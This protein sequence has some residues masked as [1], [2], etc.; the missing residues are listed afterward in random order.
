MEKEHLL[1][2]RNKPNKSNEAKVKQKIVVGLYIGKTN[3]SNELIDCLREL[4]NNHSEKLIILFGQN[5][6]TLERLRSLLEGKNLI[7]SVSK[8]ERKFALKRFLEYAKKLNADVQF[9]DLEINPDYRNVSSWIKSF[10]KVMSEDYHFAIGFFNYNPLLK[11]LDHFLLSPIIFSFYGLKVREPTSGAFC[12]NQDTVKKIVRQISISRDADKN[13][14]YIFILINMV[15]W[16]KT[17]FEV[18]LNSKHM[19]ANQNQYDWTIEAIKTLFEC[20]KEDKALVSKSPVKRTPY[21]FRLP[22]AK[23]EKST[24]FFDENLVYTFD[25]NIK[26]FRHVFEAVLDRAELVEFEKLTNTKTADIEQLMQL[27]AKIV[28]SFLR[29]YMEY[30]N[31]DKEE[32]FKALCIISSKILKITHERLL[33]I[34]EDISEKDRS[35][36]TDS[37]SSNLP[38]YFTR[39]FINLMADFTK[40]VKGGSFEKK[41]SITPLDYLEFI[42]GVPIALPKE[43][44]GSDGRKIKTGEVFRRLQGRYEKHFVQFLKMIGVS[45]TTSS[46]KIANGIKKFMQS[47]EKTIDDL[48]PGDLH[49]KEGTFKFVSKLFEKFQKENVHVIKWE[50]LKKIIYEFPPS[51]LMIRYGYRSVSSL[52]DNLDVRDVI[53]F[54]Q[55]TEDRDYFDKIFYWLEGN[56]RP[57][58][59]EEVKI[60]PMVIDRSEFPVV[61]GMKEI[62]DLNRITARI[63]VTNLGKGM[64][65]EYPKLRYFTRITKSIIEA[66]H[67][68]YIW[69][70][71]VKQ[72]KE[73]GHK[74]VN[75]ILGH[76]GK[77]IFS[78][79]HIFE[80]W[81]HRKL[82]IRLKKFADILGKR[83]QTER[84]QKIFA[85]AEGYGLSLVLKDGTFMPCSAWTW[86]SFSFKGGDF[87]PTPLSVKVERDW[88][89]HDLLE[90]I[91]K[92]QGYNPDEIIHKIFHLI[93]QGRESV[94]LAK[95][96]L[97]V[98]PYREEVVVQELEHWPKAKELERYDK[99]PILS[100]IKEH[101]WEC[102]YVLNAAALRIKDKVYLFYRALGRDN[103]SRIGLAIT[104][105]HR[106]IERLDK[107]IFVPE[108][109]QEKMGCEDPRV[110][111][112]DDEI[113]ML[114]TAYN[115]VVAQ[116]A[117]ASIKIEDFLNR[118]FDKWERRGLAFPGLWDKD[119]LLFPEKIDGQYVLYHRI[120]PSIWIAYSD[121]LCFPWPEHGH[122]IIMGPRS[123][124]MWDSL[125]IGAGSQPIKTEYGWLL[126]YHGVDRQMVY[127]LGVM[128]VDL[129]D[130]GRILY[131]SPNAIL[132][133]ETKFEIGEKGKHW[134]PNVVFTCGAV[135]A[136]DKEVLEDM[137]E[138]LVYYGAADTHICVAKG[139]IADLIPEEV[140]NSIKR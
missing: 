92:A 55:F 127:R 138:I 107:P 106:I 78:A 36:V 60:E 100:P 63:L 70:T 129:K 5:L 103:I 93:S 99:N 14:I 4:K 49:T 69:K 19:P 15:R 109:D 136:I 25:E 13:N 132:S 1:N 117:A 48:F 58:S 65:G 97:G 126:I 10:E 26:N 130:P 64:G 108:L 71:Y 9:F 95:V 67:F 31:I 61:S 104:D 75:S 43:L 121:K 68:S 50:V 113:L 123:G 140:R 139:K 101:W 53:T 118:E 6:D 86:A 119:A 90:E 62:S 38:R 44:K 82:T 115:G 72:R 12:A 18:N 40:G 79:H 120:E 125:K 42:P 59:F 112:I 3:I 32:F 8:A 116:I 56:L 33:L 7:C 135:P 134:V 91:Y 77:A 22:Y 94:D 111:V 46:E 47:L 39:E 83:G 21:N 27:W 17:I 81:H 57:D 124:L 11:G 89:N 98:I 45:D 29:K 66:E 16:Q 84:S 37:I 30:N 87:V 96:M 51:N 20:I 122:K 110:I 52:L 41:S 23:K 24:D 102:K 105:G 80:N 137:D 133:P 73:V 54:S 76:Y 131:R 28:Y 128:L 85:M 114:Y 35:I 34:N 74:F 88:F 2:N